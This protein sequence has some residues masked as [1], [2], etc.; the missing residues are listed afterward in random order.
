MGGRVD[1][2]SSVALDL[3]VVSFAGEDLGDLLHVGFPIDFGVYRVNGV[4][5][6]KRLRSGS[7]T[8][9]ALSG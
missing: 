3:R 9:K 6:V 5:F 2:W 1:E 8:H 4:S 7:G